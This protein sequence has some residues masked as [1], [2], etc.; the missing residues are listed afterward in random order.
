[1]R[2]RLEGTRVQLALGMIRLRH[3]FTVTDVSRAYPH[4]AHPRT[5]RLYVRVAPR[6]ER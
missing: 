2:I 4:R 5:Y 3:V 6:P 1:M